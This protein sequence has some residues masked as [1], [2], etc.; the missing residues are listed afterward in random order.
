MV[1]SADGGESNLEVSSVESVLV[2]I[3]MFSYRHI[4]FIEVCDV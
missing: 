1:L 3:C 4:F 2:Y